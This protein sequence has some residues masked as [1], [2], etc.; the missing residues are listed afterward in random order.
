MHRIFI[1][2]DPRQWV[3]FTVLSQSIIEHASV[4]VSITPLVLETLPLGGKHG[5][6]PFTWSR[7]LVPHL[8]GFE[9]DA[10]FL[11][12]DMLVL[13]DVGD[14]EIDRELAV[15]V[16]KSKADSWLDSKEHESLH[17]MER[18]SVMLFNCGHPDNKRLTPEYIREK[19]T[20]FI[21]WTEKV[22][23]LDPAWNVLV[24]YQKIP[25]E[26]KLLHFT[27]GVP[28]FPETQASPYGE[29]WRRC[30][31]VAA[32]T[33]PWADLMAN[34]VHTKKLEDGRVVPKLYEAA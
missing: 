27:Q 16:V 9:G 23:D 13:G 25:E 12:A 32:S 31:Q 33:L 30:L 24:G 26:P 29:H 28:A 4:P 19:R 14:L 1:G 2:F 11:D 15:S 8:C 10:L 6:T 5:L 21:D 20:T 34:S 22:G 17:M 18:A 7:F 3:S